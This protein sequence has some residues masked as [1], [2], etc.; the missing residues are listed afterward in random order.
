M[1]VAVERSYFLGKMDKIQE[2]AFLLIKRYKT[3][4]NVNEIMSAAGCA[5]TKPFMPNTAPRMNS[6]GIYTTPC[7]LIDRMS[8]E[9]AAPIACKALVNT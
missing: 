7:L 4:A 9:I 3:T 6:V 1:A 2:K 8:D 5:A